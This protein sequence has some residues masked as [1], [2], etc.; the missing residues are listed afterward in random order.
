MQ[1]SNLD[2]LKIQDER[3]CREKSL[4]CPSPLYVYI[5]MLFSSARLTWNRIVYSWHNVKRWEEEKI[6]LHV[7]VVEKSGLR[8]VFEKNSE[9]SWIQNR[10]TFCT[11]TCGKKKRKKTKEIKRE[12]K[13]IIRSKRWNTIYGL[14]QF[15]TRTCADRPSQILQFITRSKKRPESRISEF[16]PLSSNSGIV[17]SLSPSLYLLPLV[18]PLW[19]KKCIG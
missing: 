9:A 11:I 8:A 2:I 12:K 4:F 1:D 14:T 3:I 17:L 10:L 7:V 19:C 15:Q 5:Y 13:E 18:A 6:T 16:F